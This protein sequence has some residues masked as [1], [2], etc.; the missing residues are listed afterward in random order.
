M[1]FEYGKDQFVNSSPSSVLLIVDPCKRNL[2][3]P[4][5]IPRAQCAGIITNCRTAFAYART[6]KIPVAVLRG[7]SRGSK[8]CRRGGRQ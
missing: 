2:V 7:T 6:M 8:L 1:T 3:G 4:E 5:A